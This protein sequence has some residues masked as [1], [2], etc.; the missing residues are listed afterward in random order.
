MGQLF[1]SPSRPFY[2]SVAF[3]TLN[4][5]PI[6]NYSD[7]CSEH[8]RKRGKSIE[9]V[10]I[11]TMYSR[12][13]GITY[14]LQ[15]VMNELFSMTPR[16]ETCRSDDLDKAIRQI[17]DISSPIYEDLLYQLPEKQCL[18]LKALGKAG[19]IKNITSSNFIKNYGLIS[20]NSVKS[21][22]PALIDKGLVTI[23][24]GEY[25]LYDRFFQL[26]LENT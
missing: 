2:Q 18:V 26:W 25:Q 9:R 15:R 17:V 3:Y 10:V 19:K 21:A 11:D 6:D 4:I 13:E 7:F 8:F 5:L 23:E 12:F 16:N 24:H 1:T 14:Y 22:I 20:V